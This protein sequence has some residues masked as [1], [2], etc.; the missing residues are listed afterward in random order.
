MTVHTKRIS[1]SHGVE[2]RALLSLRE[3]TL[4]ADVPEAKVRKDIEI[5]LLAPL[6]SNN[7]ERLLFR[8]ADVSIF[9]A[10][11]KT[12]LLS[13]ALRKKMLDEFEALLEPSCRRRFYDRLDAEKLL[14]LTCRRD[15]PGRLLA[16]RDRLPLDKYLFIDL[17]EVA[18]DIAP[19]VNL[20]AEGLSR[21]E[22]KEGV[23]GGET[24][25]RGTRLSV[26]HIGKMYDGG[27]SVE[28]IV[29][30]Y[31]YLRKNDIE[32]ARLYYLAHPTIGRP[33]KHEEGELAGTPPAR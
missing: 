18:G 12:E 1:P 30:D 22:E 23:L 21:I 11:Y 4:L 7:T 25:F 19:R 16:A 10:I 20:Y 26:R 9:A 8:W 32:F 6:R 31:P 2:I 3:A 17:E 33:S 28:I 15:Q 14:S 24:V 27:E 29:A 13:T 5:G